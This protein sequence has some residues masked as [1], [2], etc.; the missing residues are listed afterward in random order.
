VL[1]TVSAT[2]R[3][4]R[5]P[6][7]KVIGSIGVLAAAA[8][9]AGMGTFGAFTNSTEALDSHVDTGT[10]SIDLAAPTQQIDFPDVDGC[11]KPGERSA[12]V[13][14]LV[15]S[16]TS[17]PSAVKLHVTALVSSLLD[18]DRTKGLQLTIDG[19]DHA[20]DTASGQYS[21]AGTVTRHYAGPVVLSSQLPAAA[22]LA[23]GGVDHLLATVTLPEA[24]GN[25]FM[26]AQTVLGSCSPVRSGT[27]L[28]LDR[29]RAAAGQPCVRAS[30]AS[31]VAVLITR[32]AGTPHST[33]RAQPASC[34]SS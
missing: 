7:A 18:A 12:M 21:C 24:A 34:Q 27:A 26:G 22:S 14:D 10:V 9:V 33:A 2:A 4:T 19:C 13:I 1:V 25:E 29:A 5:R 30:N 31:A 20:W 28:P 11:W 17:A 8:A 6:A 3:T 23:S 15:N 32:S 16:G